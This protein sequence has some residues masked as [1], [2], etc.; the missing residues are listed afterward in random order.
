MPRQSHQAK[1]EDI[2]RDALREFDEIQAAVR[3]ERLQCVDDRRFYAVPGAQWW[4]GLGDQFEHKPKFEINK[5]HLSVIRIY[6]EYRN[7]RITVDFQS[8]DGT[9]DDTMADTCDGLYRADEQAC[10]ADEAYDNCFE[11]GT[12]G[13]MGAIRLRTVNEDED[14]DDNDRKS[15]AIEPVFEADKSVFFDL[16]AK[17][18]DKADAKRC[19]LLTAY[20]HR[21]YEEE[22]NDTPNSWPQAICDWQFDWY[23]PEV[24]WVC[25]L[26]RVE[27][28]KVLV[29]WFKPLGDDAEE[30]RVTEDELTEEYL[31]ELLATGHREVRQKRVR[32]R[33]V[34]K[35][36]MSGG[37]M[38]S[39]GEQIAGKCIPIAP[40]HGKRL[41]VDGVERYMGHVR[42]AKD[43]QRLVNMLMSWLADIAARSPIEVPIMT[44]EQIGQHGWMWAE[45]NVKNFPYL[46][47]EAQRD[48]A[49]NPL[50]G[51][52]VP[53][54]YTKVPNIPPALAALAQ[55]ATQALED[56]LGNQQAG[57]QMEPNLSGKAVELIQNRLDMQTFIYMSNFAKTIKRCGEIWLSM[58]REICVEES[59]R[60]KTI[61]LNGE[62][63]SVVVNEPAYD[64]QTG[65]EIVK[66]DLTAANFE[67]N[68]DVGPSSSSRRQATVR[69]LIGMKQGTQDPEMLAVLDGLIMM[70]MEGEGIADA[71][72]W[73]RNKMVRM[74][75]VKPTEEERAELAQAAANQPPDPNAVYLQAAAEEAQANAGN[76]RA[77]TVQTIA[78]A[79]L[80]R[81]QTAKTYAEV[82]DNHQAQLIGNYAALREML[83]P[84]E[85]AAA[86]F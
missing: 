51:T 13:G 27:E 34:M 65:A 42:L 61:G 9:T 67:V 40:F 35:Y 4:G 36:L 15:V 49:G 86:A 66:N 59:R 3:D 58:K 45:H 84:P 30:L 47:A 57:E 69:A 10:T 32:S 64:S 50:P 29:H 60:M 52:Q 53:A 73:A 77:K 80:K 83:Q 72:E 43:A 75:V 55:M 22:F 25:E 70:N 2:H 48:D 71:R 8:R 81:A 1:L 18:Y 82:M 46:L 21:A 76:A 11:E 28:T 16:D 6:S 56:M 5:V 33:R 20:T 31:A 54:A 62:I 41:I 12:A 17:R 85:P 26:Y 19:Y 78:D 7:N 37:K 39:K 68:V 14:D 38:L 24:V 74:G 79:D 44:P 23:T 63:G